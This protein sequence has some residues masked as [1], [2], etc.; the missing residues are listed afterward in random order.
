MV[1]QKDCIYSFAKNPLEAIKKAREDW[2]GENC[3][4]TN[5]DPRNEDDLPGI[6]VITPKLYNNLLLTEDENLDSVQFTRFKYGYYGAYGER[7]EI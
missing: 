5:C 7:L 1:K 6:V 4:I 2:L 3:E